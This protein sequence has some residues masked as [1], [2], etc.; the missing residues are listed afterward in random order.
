MSRP[1]LEPCLEPLPEQR[2]R[3]QRPDNASP[4]VGQVAVA[5]GAAGAAQKDWV[6]AVP[7]DPGGHGGG[8]LVSPLLPPP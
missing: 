2:R 4:A 5:E 7:A 8:A 6:A 3:C 1:R